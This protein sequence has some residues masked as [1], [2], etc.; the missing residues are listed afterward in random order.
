MKT[1]IWRISPWDVGS[2]FSEESCSRLSSEVL[3]NHV[4]KEKETF[5]SCLSK[6]SL[7]QKNTNSD[8]CGYE[9]Q[10]MLLSQ[11]RQGHFIWTD[12]AGTLA[13]C[14]ACT[15]CCCRFQFHF[16]FHRHREKLQTLAW[17][18]EMSTTTHLCWHSPGLHINL[19]G[20][21]IYSGVWYIQ[22]PCANVHKHTH[23]IR[24]WRPRMLVMTRLAPDAFSHPFCCVKLEKRG[25]QRLDYRR[26][27]TINDMNHR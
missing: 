11:S 27:D 6:W 20:T 1:D 9:W 13:C 23:N 10:E 21:L 4:N 2:Y 18:I 26:D 8:L 3:I 15:Y 22:R 5:W 17:F 7:H 12:T 25:G 19:A 16:H 24:E 14:T